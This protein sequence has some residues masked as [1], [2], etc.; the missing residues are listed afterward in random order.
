VVETK[1][2]WPWCCFVSR[3]T[4]HR[5]AGEKFPPGADHWLHCSGLISI[6]LT[7]FWRGRWLCDTPPGC[8]A[9]DTLADTV[10]LRL[11]WAC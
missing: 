11:I 1:L 2:P 5:L 4:G 7:E 3:W 6:F 8:A 10:H 9:W